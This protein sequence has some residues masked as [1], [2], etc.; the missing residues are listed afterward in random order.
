[1]HNA[2]RIVNDLDYILIKLKKT[3]GSFV[4]E[5]SES[6]DRVVRN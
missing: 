6:L 2:E 4:I 5:L 1:M 3:G